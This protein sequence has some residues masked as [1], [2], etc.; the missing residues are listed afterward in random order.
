MTMNLHS[1]DVRLGALV[2]LA[3]G[4]GAAFGIAE[5]FAAGLLAGA[6]MLVFVGI[7]HLGGGRFDALDVMGGGGDERTR[8][9]SARAIAFTGAV[10]A[11]VIVGWWLVTLIQGDVDETLTVLAAVGGISFVASALLFSRRG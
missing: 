9:L 6:W 7:L 10:L 5:G 11:Y 4:T 2:A 8:A 1:P 3:L